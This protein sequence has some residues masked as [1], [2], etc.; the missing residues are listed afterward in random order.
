MTGERTSGAESTASVFPQNMAQFNL[1]TTQASSIWGDQIRLDNKKSS[2]EELIGEIGTTMIPP[3]NHV[4]VVRY[5]TEQH[6]IQKIS[7]LR[8]D[9]ERNRGMDAVAM[10]EEFVAS[11]IVLST[12]GG[13][14]Y[15]LS[16]DETT[17]VNYL[18]GAEIEL[19]EIAALA[20]I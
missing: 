10:G 2:Y 15:A 12:E 6:E 3:E 1:A 9:A 11:K 19:L 13:G 5:R 18:P 4:F 8:W 14:A 7:H 20:S 17:C 16:P